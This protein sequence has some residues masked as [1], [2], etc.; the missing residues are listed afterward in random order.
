MKKTILLTLC[1]LLAFNLVGLAKE[2][3]QDSLNSMQ[4]VEKAREQK[5]IN[6]SL[7]C[8]NIA[9]K[10]DPKNE[11][12]YSDRGYLKAVLGAYDESLKDL[13]TV[14]KL[15]PKNHTGYHDI[16]TVYMYQE[17]YDK[18]LE[19]L[20]KAIEINPLYVDSYINM[21]DV[22]I[23]KTNRFEDAFNTL[24]KA[25]DAGIQS[26]LIHRNKARFFSALSQNDLAIIEYSTAI[27]LDNSDA[28]LYLERGY[29]YRAVQDYEK[30]IAD[31]TAGIKTAKEKAPFY[32]A[33]GISYRDLGKFD[34]ALKD[35]DE[36]IN[37]KGI[38]E[39]WTQ[40][41]FYKGEL[42]LILDDKQK[43]LYN[44]QTFLQI[45]TPDQKGSMNIVPLAE[46]FIA[47]LKQ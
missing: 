24:D 36:A 1:L 44:F 41:Y 10:L 43:A 22:Y 13:F 8:I 12:A 4:W 26:P 18:A 32:I 34:E 17:E 3:T 28:Q 30:A 40:G 2:K 21:A 45:V 25:I 47:K 6:D 7:N 33:R 46:D 19:Y 38:D 16:G 23:Y 14:I 39:Y 31:F 11:Q 27:T 20:N 5:N 37:T 42:Y 15:N 29:T 9:I 35:Y